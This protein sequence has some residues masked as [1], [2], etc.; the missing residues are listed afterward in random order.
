MAG[1]A[2]SPTRLPSGIPGQSFLRAEE[3][4]G[5]EENRVALRCVHAV[6]DESGGRFGTPRAL[7]WLISDEWPD[8]VERVLDLDGRSAFRRR[9]VEDFRGALR[10]GRPVGPLRLCTRETQTG[11][12]SWM[13][14]SVGE[15]EAQA[16]LEL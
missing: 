16:Q 1:R 2:T 12:P 15:A 7:Y 9:Q 4:R 13:L 10:Q 5:L 8:G 3:R 11:R 6:L 14:L